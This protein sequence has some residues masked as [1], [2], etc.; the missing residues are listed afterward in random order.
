[1]SRK[2]CIWVGVFIAASCW[3]GFSAFGQVPCEFTMP[4]S[5]I[6]SSQFSFSYWHHD[7]STTPGIDASAGQVAAQFARIYDSPFFGYTM[8]FNTRV[9]LDTLLAQSWLGS[10]AMSYRYYISEELP[11]FVYAG[12]RIEAATYQVQPGCELRSGIGIGRL[13]DVTP[14]AKAQR[15]IRSLQ[16]DG[17]ITQPLPR[18]ELLQIAEAIAREESHGE[19][20]DYVADVAE[21]I[22]SAAGIALGSP[23]VLTVSEELEKPSGELFCG[24]ILQG[25]VGYELIDPYAGLQDVLYVMSGDVAHAPTANSLLRCRMSWS[26]ASSDFLGENITILNIVY[27][28]DLRNSNAVKA[29]YTIKNITAATTSAITMQTATTEYALAMGRADLVFSLS[30][31][32]QTGDPDWSIDISVSCALDLL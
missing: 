16:A 10:G 27:N 21:T 23:S 7:D 19:F 9:E 24:A 14:L 11:L 28:A 5:M 31:S 12:T 3:I 4:V 26:G 13:R 25:G 2:L 1:M 17:V 6:E 18:R 30:L 22:E 20:E 29:G 15:I 32:K 8:S